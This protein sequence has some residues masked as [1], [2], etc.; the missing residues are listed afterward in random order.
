MITDSYKGIT[1][2]SY[3]HL[4]LPQV[5]GFENGNSIEFVYTA[6]GTKLRK[7]V[8]TGG[9]ITYEQDYMNGIEYRKVGTSRKVEAIY[10]QEGRR[11]NTNVTT[12]SSVLALRYEFSMRDHHAFVVASLRQYPPDFHRQGRRRRY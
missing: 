12:T 2:I 4:N 7:T 3:N 11:C 9:V 6:A 10:H 8:K 1:N 5:I